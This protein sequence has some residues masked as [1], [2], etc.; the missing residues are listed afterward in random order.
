MADS[1]GR[2]VWYE[3][4]TT[5]VEAAMAFYTKVMGW[6]AWDASVP[7]RAYILFT[8]GED[9]VSG[10]MD[11][12][13]DARKMG[14]KPS[15][16][17]YVGVNDVDAAADRVKRLG[18]AVHVPPTDIPN[19]SRFSVFADPQTARLA[20]FKW[21]K[22]GQEQPAELSTPGR[23]G[24]HELLAADWEKALAFYGELFGWQKA[25]ADI[26]AMGTY[27]LFSA[28][29]QTIGGM[30]T[31]PPMVPVPFWLYYFNIGDIDAAAKRVKAGGGQILDGPIEVPGG[32]WFVRC[33][34]PQGAM[35]ALIGK[36]SNKG[37]G[38]FERVASRDPSDARGR[39]W[40]W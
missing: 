16:V 33:T 30:F 7:G 15:W 13:E 26:D 22:P 20:L 8:I 31:K 6:G 21:L 4:M 18:G 19:I 35:F 5:D 28:G 32:S 12:S 24:W 39:R 11:L 34:D 37:I 14:A 38:Y 40:S 2:F 10:L 9:A 27:Q 29:G 17:G 3:L 36:R 23:V 1:H 25:D